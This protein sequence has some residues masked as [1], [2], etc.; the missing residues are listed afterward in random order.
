MCMSTHHCLCTKKRWQNPVSTQ[1]AHL[2]VNAVALVFFIKIATFKLIC[3]HIDSFAPCFVF[4]LSTEMVRTRKYIRSDKRKGSGTSVKARGRGSNTHRGNSKGNSKGNNNNSNNSK[5]KG[6][7]KEIDH[8]LRM[9]RKNPTKVSKQALGE[10][11]RWCAKNPKKALGVVAMLA[12]TGVYG[13]R[14]VGA[15]ARGHG[16][17]ASDAAA[18]GMWEAQNFMGRVCTHFNW[19]AGVCG[20]SKTGESPSE[21]DDNVMTSRDSIYSHTDESAYRDSDCESPVPD[22]LDNCMLEAD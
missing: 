13:A 11:V 17:A 12:Y 2:H 19:S 14:G 16:A 15:A 1:S 18:L 7:E 6:E 21:Y 8:I 22:L 20:T 5:D 10:V 9:I 4:P 3:F